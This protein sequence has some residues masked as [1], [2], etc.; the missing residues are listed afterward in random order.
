MNDT[1]S[2]YKALDYIRDNA[3]AY[4]VAKASVSYLTEFRKTI[5]A[6]LMQQSDAKTESA[7]ESYAYAHIDY[8]AHIKALAAAVQEY[9][10]LRWLMVAAEAKIS[11]WQTLEATARIEMKASNI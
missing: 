7:K 6:I 11:V 10:R 4:A 2:P 3:E 9:E 5:K 1:I 8:I